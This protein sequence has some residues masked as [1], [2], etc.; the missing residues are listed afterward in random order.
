MK[1]IFV[2]L[3]TAFCFLNKT[4][5]KNID[6]LKN[7]LAAAKED[8]AKVILLNKIGNFYKSN[9][10]DSA[11]Y[12]FEES[13]KLS[14]KLRYQEG[15]LNYYL[16]VKDPLVQKGEIEKFIKAS[17][18]G[19]ELAKKL[20]DENRQAI[21][22]QNTGSGYYYLAKLDSCIDYYKKAEIIFEK[23]KNSTELVKHYGN[24]SAVY[25]ES[26]LFAKSLEYGFKALK[27]QEQG[28][29]NKDDL[30]YVY[31]S[32]YVTYLDLKLIDS[33]I[34]YANKTL[35][36]CRVD[37][38]KALEHMTLGNMMNIKVDQGKYQELFPLLERL[39]EISKE[40]DNPENN[41]NLYMR[42]SMAYYYNGESK[43]AEE[44]A[45]KV[46]KIVEAN[47]LSNVTKN[48]YILLNVIEASLGNYALA[49]LYGSKRD[50]MNDLAIN[51]V[52]AKNIQE[53]EKKYETQKKET[54]IVKLNASN[55][56]KSTLNQIVISSAVGLIL[57]SLLGYRNFKNKQKVSSQQQEI[58]QQKITELEKDKQLS[59]IDA[60]L[61][62]QEDERSRI[63]KDLHDGLGGMLSGTK[64]S[65]INMKENLVLTPENATL[66]DKSISMLDNTIADLRKVAHNLMPEALVKFGLDEAVKDF[67]SS[68]QSS[69]NLKVVYQQVGEKRKLTNTAEVFTYRIIQELVNNAIK[70]AA[71]TQIIVQLNVNTHKLSITVEDDGK[72]FDVNSIANSKSAGMDNIKYRVQ[73]FNGTLDIVTAPGKGTSVN[74]DLTA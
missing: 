37:K 58:Q 45:F 7:V 26:K 22:Y 13:K 68:I 32:I 73:Y 3:V 18:L 14:E 12:Y 52:T 65:F 41:A 36:Q 66:F 55:K 4:K 62:G 64:L 29:G 6:S 21:F 9:K 28:F 48:A 34:I 67:C 74:I 30:S 69:S 8:T 38:N 27:L 70:H 23:N 57:F 72:G 63:A 44:Y 25:G 43:M 15:V 42:T 17:K 54:E 24:A 16:N 40:I 33:A 53:L 61:K 5:A 39:K 60:M 10:F 19:F 20:G 71:A 35:Q 1:R 59:A 2:C 50:S 11:L 49:D 51:E 31:S 47:K 46:L 56:Q